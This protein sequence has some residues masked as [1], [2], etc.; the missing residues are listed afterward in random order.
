MTFKNKVTRNVFYCY[1]SI[2]VLFALLRMLCSFNVLRFSA[3]GDII[4]NIFTQVGIIFALPVFAFSFL[5]KEK[6]K[7]TLKFFGY[8]KI[9]FKAVLI[10]VAMGV[11]VYILNIFVAN[12]FAI[13]LTALGYNYPAS[14]GGTYPVW[15]LFV[16]LV[17][18]AVLPAICEETAHRGL[19]LK[20]LSPLGRRRAVIISG[21][22]F[23]L[24]HM[25]IQQFFYATLIGLLLGYI[26]S[27]C[28]SIYPA[29]I[30]HFMNNA[31]STIMGFS[32]SNN[33][34]FTFITDFINGLLVTK[35][36]LAVI[37][38]IA[39]LVLLS[40]LLYLLIKQLLKHTIVKRT[41]MLQNEIFKELAKN[42]YMQELEEVADGSTNLPDQRNVSFEEF[43]ALYKQVGIK[44][45]HFSSLEVKLMFDDTP[46]K[47]DKV[48]KI[49]MIFSIILSSALTLLTFILGCL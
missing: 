46:Y 14:T 32:Y 34:G 13:I 30:I 38:V 5:Q 36:A 15:L 23:G 16:N 18:T 41:A 24:L 7:D 4:L 9:S 48:T 26:S 1:F 12:F 45:G 20:G 25:N 28:D 27:C 2:V 8:K 42:T 43:D 17:L 39:L 35:P 37:F 49:L 19:L 29:M 21:L 3:V 31:L 6:P 10:A 44:L 47:M 40:M 33:L 11:T 22:L